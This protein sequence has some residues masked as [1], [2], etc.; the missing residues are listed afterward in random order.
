MRGIAV[1]LLVASTAAA[2]PPPEP[3]ACGPAAIAAERERLHTELVKLHHDEHY[4]AWLSRQRLSRS[5]RRW[6]YVAMSGGTGA[7]AGFA[8]YGATHGGSVRFDAGSFP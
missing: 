4:Q 5:L 2:D 8:I 3:C 6:S 7:L 1:A